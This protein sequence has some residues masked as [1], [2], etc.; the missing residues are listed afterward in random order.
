MEQNSYKLNKMLNQSICLLKCLAELLTCLKVHLCDITNTTWDEAS[1]WCLALGIHTKSETFP[2]THTQFC[3]TS[4]TSCKSVKRNP[5]RDR[6]HDE[7]TWTELSK[8]SE[9]LKEDQREEKQEEVR[10]HT[11]LPFM[12]SLPFPWLWPC[13]YFELAWPTSCRQPA[14]DLCLTWGHLR[15]KQSHCFSLVNICWQEQN[16]LYFPIADV[17]MGSQQGTEH[18]YLLLIIWWHVCARTQLL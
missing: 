1:Y 10:C 7:K 4:V 8:P 14:V 13:S 2:R 11:E 15:D 12:R 17:L 16:I 5:I 18:T 6:D 3:S 9:R